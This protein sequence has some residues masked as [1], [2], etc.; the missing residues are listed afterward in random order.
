MMGQ[1]PN[2]R[3]I[4]GV[5]DNGDAATRPVP[6]VG[7]ARALKLAAAKQTVAVFLRARGGHH[8]RRD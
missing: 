6:T 5:T 8:S 2:A 1:L 4:A 7:I 3:P